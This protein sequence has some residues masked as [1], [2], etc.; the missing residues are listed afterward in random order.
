MLN[1]HQWPE[2]APGYTEKGPPCPC[3]EAE[4]QLAAKETRQC[5]G[6]Y[7]S[8]SRWDAVDDSQCRVRLSGQLCALFEVSMK[9]IIILLVINS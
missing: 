8:G 2:T 7:S 3:T 5:V 1:G 4:G 6:T 9:S